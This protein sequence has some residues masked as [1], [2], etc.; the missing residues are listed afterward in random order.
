MN[1]AMTRK[2]Y[3]LYALAVFCWG[4]SWIA[5]KLQAVSSAPEAAVFWRF[6]L[7]TPLMFLWALVSRQSLRFEWRAHGLFLLAGV[8]LFST[9]FMLY[10]HAGRLLTSGLLP[11]LF[12]LSIIGNLVMGALFL[13]QRITLRLVLG[14]LI[15]IVGVA[16]LF[17]AEFSKIETSDT[18]WLGILFCSVGTISFCIGSTASALAT[19]RASRADAPAPV[20]PVTA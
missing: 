8:G 2:D 16:L 4:T 9:N 12:S 14:A 1:K 6:V 19:I 7:A 17:S 11:V 10:Y 3:L 20:V 13:G 18:L 5:L 15:G